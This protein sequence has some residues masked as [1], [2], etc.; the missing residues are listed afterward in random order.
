VNIWWL[1]LGLAGWS[2]ALRLAGPLLLTR[3][4]VPDSASRVLNNITPAVLSALIVAGM[5]SSGRS[6]VLDERA[7]GFAAAAVGALLKAPPLVVIVLA[8]GAT[9][10]ARALI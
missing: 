7:F 8:A 2:Y 4:A 6:L 1:I 5:F 9:A 3:V 10:A